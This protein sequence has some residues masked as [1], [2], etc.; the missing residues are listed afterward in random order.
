[1]M[2]PCKSGKILVSLVKFHPWI[3]EIWWIQTVTQ[4]AT[5]RIRNETIISPLTFGRGDIIIVIIICVSCTDERMELKF[6]QY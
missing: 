5:P 4:M 3:Q 1:M 6:Y 2:Y